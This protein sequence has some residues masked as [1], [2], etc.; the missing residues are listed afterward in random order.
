MAWDLKRKRIVNAPTAS[1]SVTITRT[2][3][4]QRGMIIGGTSDSMLMMRKVAEVVRESVGAAEGQTMFESDEEEKDEEDARD[5][6]NEKEKGKE[7]EKEKEKEK[8]KE[9]VSAGTDT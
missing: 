9:G 1:T 2:I 7:K 3:G 6:K 5:K 4:L 8:A